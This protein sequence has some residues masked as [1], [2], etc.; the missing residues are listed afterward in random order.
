[1][2]WQSNSFPERHIATEDIICYKVFSKKDIVWETL[3]G[4][5]IKKMIKV[6]SLYRNYS[7]VPYKENP[8]VKLTCYKVDRITNLII[9]AGYHSYIS[10]LA[11]KRL[12]CSNFNIIECVIPKDSFYYINNRG[13]TV[14]SN[15]IVTDKIVD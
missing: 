3:L 5:N 4:S 12:Y 9:N 11:A 7:Y 2:C 8:E 13:E 15:L 1:M 6:A 14:S 10:L